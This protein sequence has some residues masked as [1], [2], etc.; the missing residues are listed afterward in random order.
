MQTVRITLA[1]AQVLR[2]FVADPSAGQYGY[3]LMK[4]TGFPSGKL[5]P[6][7]A[8]LERAGVLRKTIEAIDPAIEAR[9]ARR[10][11]NLTPDGL[12]FARHELAKLH[13]ELAGSTS[14]RAIGIHPSEVGT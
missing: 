5:Y 4:A 9:P 8:R 1:V 11:Y 10:V 12:E 3:G 14:T 13:A 6:I 7:L 2:V